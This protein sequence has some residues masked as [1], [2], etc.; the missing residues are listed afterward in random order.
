MSTLFDHLVLFV[1]TSALVVAFLCL[2]ILLALLSKSGTRRERW[3]Y[4]VLAANPWL[5]VIVFIDHY[6]PD[7]WR[8]FQNWRA[9]RRGCVYRIDRVFATREK[10]EGRTHTVFVFGERIPPEA[11]GS[12]GEPS[13]FPRTHPGFLIRVTYQRIANA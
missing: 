7:C 5:R 6:G 4:G 1:L 10:P 13:P 11:H 12:L 3:A 2:C 9:A 8:R